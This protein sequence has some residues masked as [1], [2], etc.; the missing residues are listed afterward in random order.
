M[1]RLSLRK[2]LLDKVLFKYTRI[3]LSMLFTCV[4]SR[5]KYFNFQY[6][7]ISTAGV[8]FSFILILFIDKYNSTSTHKLLKVQL[9]NGCIIYYLLFRPIKNIK[10]L[11][12]FEGID[13]YLTI[14]DIFAGQPQL[15]HHLVAQI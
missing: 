4:C 1:P 3:F 6:K 12:S 9:Q 14:K 10:A 2:K 5:A 13:S 8:E 11:N 7:N 15:L